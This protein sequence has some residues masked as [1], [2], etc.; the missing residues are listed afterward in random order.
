MACRLVGAKPLSD[1][2]WNIV[3]WNLRNKLQWNL[4]RNSYIFIHKNA[5]E[6]VVCEMAAICSRPQCVKE[7]FISCK[8]I[9]MEKI[10]IYWILLYPRPTKLVYL[11][12]LVHPSVRLS[13]LLG[14]LLTWCCDMEMLPTLLDLCEGNPPVTDGFSSQFQW[15]LKRNLNIFASASVC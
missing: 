15:N 12:N 6:N 14:S 1:Q 2:C 3:N 5:F 7:C 9:N 10:Y 13:F 8:F 11:I 4:K